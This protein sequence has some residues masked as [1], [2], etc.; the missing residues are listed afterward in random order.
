[1]SCCSGY[2]HHY[3]YFSP[4]IRDWAER[5]EHQQRQLEAHPHWRA[6]HPLQGQRLRPREGLPVPYQSG[7][8]VRHQRL[9][10]AGIL[11]RT[12]RYVMCRCNGEEGRGGKE[13]MGEQWRRRGGKGGGG[14][15]NWRLIIWTSLY[16]CVWLFSYI[17]EEDKY[18]CV[19]ICVVCELYL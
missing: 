14:L 18:L 3:P 15:G 4:Q 10:H 17:W 16:F 7:Q 11:L 6:G 19:W 2:L 12:C 8:R 9:Y 5:L 13:R 1:M